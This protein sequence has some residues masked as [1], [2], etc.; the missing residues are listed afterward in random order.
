MRVQV[1]PQ[2]KQWIEQSSD[3]PENK[4]KLLSLP[5][6]SHQDIINW[7]KRTQ[8]AATLK[9]VFAATTLEWPKPAA[10]PTKEKTPEYVEL[11]RR[12]RLEAKEKEYQQLLRAKPKYETLYE[13]PL[14]KDTPLPAQAA[15][16]VKSQI[17]TM[18]NIFI[19]VASVAYAVWYW[20]ASSWGLDVVWRVLLSVLA[21]LL[22]LVAEV[23]VYMGYLRRIDEA[24]VRERSKKEVKKV[25][26][27]LDATK[28]GVV[29]EKS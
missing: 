7:Y 8:P 27:T 6:P 22:V 14:T 3:T 10:E 20:T 5:P 12:L 19:S 9:E 2:L 21:G 4:R 26:R 1:A 23:V 24:R 15:K 28:E 29:V 13:D 18:F 16:E 25:I 17:T 11:M